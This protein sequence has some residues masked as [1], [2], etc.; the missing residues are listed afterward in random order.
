MSLINAPSIPVPAAS[1]RPETVEGCVTASTVPSPT[2]A[3][4]FPVIILPLL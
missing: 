3:C 4:V 1:T 2:A